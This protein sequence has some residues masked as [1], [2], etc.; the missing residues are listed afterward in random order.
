M[1]TA[2][3]N[4]IPPISQSSLKYSWRKYE[5]KWFEKYW[6]KQSYQINHDKGFNLTEADIVF[7]TGFG[8]S[9]MSAKYPSTT[10]L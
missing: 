10:S 2:E 9:E 8:H 3:F 4:Q 6:L 7:K 5:K 1:E